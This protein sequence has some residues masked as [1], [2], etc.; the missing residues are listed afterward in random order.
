MPLHKNPNKSRMTF[1]VYIICQWKRIK[2]LYTRISHYFSTKTC[3]YWLLDEFFLS[4]SSNFPHLCFCLPNGLMRMIFDYPLFPMPI[5]DHLVNLFIQWITYMANLMSHSSKLELQKCQNT[6][7][8]KRCSQSRC[9]VGR[10]WCAMKFKIALLQHS[11]TQRAR[12]RKRGWIKCIHTLLIGIG[13]PRKKC[14]TIV[15]LKNRYKYTALGACV[16]DKSTWQK[17]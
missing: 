2:L 16:S 10:I 5:W 15:E 12:K 14:I 9:V 7:R 17:W 3:A 6:T 1:C 11:Q 4:D 13:K 8:H